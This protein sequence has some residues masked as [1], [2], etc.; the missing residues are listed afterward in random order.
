MFN[1]PV[2]PCRTELV[3][4]GNLRSQILQEINELE[5]LLGERMRTILRTESSMYAGDLTSLNTVHQV[6][7]IICIIQNI[8]CIQDMHLHIY[9]M[10]ARDLTT[11][12]TRWGILYTGAYHTAYSMYIVYIYYNIN[13]LYAVY[14]DIM[15]AGDLTSLHTVHQV[16][17]IVYRGISYSI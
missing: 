6:G 12:S 7:Y 3:E 13:M 4:L 9:I 5:R 16:G 11:L 10:Y 15:Y 17:Y 2:T 14:I 8:A 1:F